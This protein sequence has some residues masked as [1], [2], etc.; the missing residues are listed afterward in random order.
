MKKYLKDKKGRLIPKG[1]HLRCVRCFDVYPVYCPECKL[2]YCGHCY[3]KCPKCNNISFR[4]NCNHNE[5][6]C[7]IDFK[8]CRFYFN[9]QKVKDYGG[10]TNKKN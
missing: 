5:F 9:K 4:K 3:T 7:D 8:S 6:D 10:K 1:Y 2:E